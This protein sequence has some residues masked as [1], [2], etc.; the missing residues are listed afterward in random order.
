MYDR[1]TLQLANAISLREPEHL[2][3]ILSG[4]FVGDWLFIHR[5]A[6]GERGEVLAWNQATGIMQTLTRPSSLIATRVIC[7]SNLIVLLKDAE[8]G[9]SIACVYK[10]DDDEP[11]STPKLVV[12]DE[13]LNMYYV[14]GYCRTHRPQIINSGASV[15]MFGIAGLSIER[16]RNCVFQLRSKHD[17][18]LRAVIDGCRDE[19]LVREK[20]T[21]LLN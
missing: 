7:I 16:A 11:G 4:D 13:S 15:D 3:F 6:W 14:N 19:I 18:S 8:R 21:F 9:V 20:S 2:S 5:T 17:F 1:W 12:D 10:C